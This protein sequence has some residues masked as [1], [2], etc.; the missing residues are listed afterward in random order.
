MTWD[1]AVAIGSL[2]LMLT[3]GTYF[4]T[5]IEAVAKD[6]KEKAQ[7]AD[8]KAQKALDAI[9][10]L[11][12]IRNNLSL[13]ISALKEATDEIKQIARQQNLTLPPSEYRRPGR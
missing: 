5:N 3:S 6:A 13:T 10:D 7:T 9:E 8:M 2:G 11:D 4:I 12:V 1:R